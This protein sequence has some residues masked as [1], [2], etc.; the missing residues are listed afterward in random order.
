MFRIAQ[1]IKQSVR[2]ISR[3]NSDVWP[4]DTPVPRYGNRMQIQ[5]AS[6]NLAKIN[7]CEITWEGI[8]VLI[9]L[10]DFLV[11]WI[12]VGA[13]KGRLL[14]TIFCRCGFMMVQQCNIPNKGLTKIKHSPN[15]EKLIA[16][17][18]F[19]FN[20][21]ILTKRKAR[22]FPANISHLHPTR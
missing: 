18:I 9:S 14:S 21:H 4:S 12:C 17:K 19:L 6:V 5:R 16:H 20:N 7:C 8:S 15:D 10:K 22:P 1:S 3:G 2:A 11:V 13:E